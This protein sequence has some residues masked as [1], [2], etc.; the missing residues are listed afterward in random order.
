MVY[1]FGGWLLNLEN[2]LAIG[3]DNSSVPHATKAGACYC[4]LHVSIT[5]YIFVCSRGFVVVR[6]YFSKHNLAYSGGMHPYHLP[7]CTT[8]NTDELACHST[9]GKGLQIRHLLQLSVELAL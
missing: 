9:T 2:G 5:I 8:H 4:L 6:W 7:D 1:M 3:L